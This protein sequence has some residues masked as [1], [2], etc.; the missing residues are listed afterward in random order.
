MVVRSCRW[1]CRQDKGYRG[2]W[3][4]VGVGKMAVRCMVVGFL[5]ARVR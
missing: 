3:G 4:V 1:E 5:S 2:F